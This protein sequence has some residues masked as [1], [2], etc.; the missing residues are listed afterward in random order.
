MAASAPS[1]ADQ[2]FLDDLDKKLW[3]AADRL[4][5][6]GFAISVYGQGKRTGRPFDRAMRARRVRPNFTRSKQSNSST[7]GRGQVRETGLR[8]RKGEVLFIDARQLGYMKDRVLRDFTPAD[9]EKISGTFRAWK[10]DIGLTQSREEREEKQNTPS[11]L[12]AFASSRENS[13]YSDTPGFCKSTTLAEI[14]AHGHVL[15]PGR[16]VG[17]E[18]VADDGE[19]FD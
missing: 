4:R 19:P 5:S 10:R 6:H 7:S 12:C 8:D 16:Y 13:R 14:A 9:L 17:A 18:D 11:A 15:T 3:N 2:P 1:S